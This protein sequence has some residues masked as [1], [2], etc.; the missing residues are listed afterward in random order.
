MNANH[1]TAFG[2]SPFFFFTPDEMPD[3][4]F[5]YH[6]QIVDHAHFVP[7]SVPLVQLPQPVAWVFVTFF[8]A[9]L[10]L[11]FSDL[12]AVQYFACHAVFRFPVLRTIHTSTARAGVL[13]PDISPAEA[14]VHSTRCNQ[15]ERDCLFLFFFGHE[16]PLLHCQLP[17]PFIP[18]AA[19]TI[20][21]AFQQLIDLQKTEGYNRRKFK[22][23]RTQKR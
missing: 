15:I 21:Y 9:I 19:Y 11:P 20:R 13:F 18:V 7:G 4:G 5:T 16:V 22:H 1:V 2:T 8:G 10:D 6:I 17:Y 14:A 3:S 12:F 23:E